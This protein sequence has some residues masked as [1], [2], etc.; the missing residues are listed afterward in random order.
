MK[1]I[2]LIDYENFARERLSPAAYGYYSD[3]ASDSITLAENRR[4]Y[5][6]IRILPHVLRDVSQRDLSATVLGQTI[7]F[8]VVIAPMAMAALAHPDKEIGIANAAKHFGIPMCLSTLATTRLETI[9]ETGVKPWFQL[10]VHRDRGLTRELVKRA[11]YAG[12]QALVVTVDVPVAG[13]RENLVRN[14]LI[15][16]EGMEPENVVDYWDREKFPSTNAYV[17][18]QFDPSLTWKDIE[19]FIAHTDIPVL[20]KGILRADDAV[21]AVES[22]VAGII[23]SNHGGRQLDTVPATIEVLPEIA[24][25]VDGRCEVL[26]DGGIRRGTDILK[27][28]ALGAKAVM[29]GRPI[30][31]GL[32]MDGQA[33]VE[34][35]LTILRREYDI[36]LALAGCVASSDI[37]R[38]IVDR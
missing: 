28:L 26:V 31:W 13:Y 15:L 35:I 10:Y 8:P 29:V 9:A 4:A 33:G 20:V 27:A 12:Y 32:A 38:D 17:A 1:P 3:G 18:A 6:R 19:D 34:D 5:D 30:L 24:E 14:P 11:E 2:N 36:A 37:P 7:E 21:Q 25:A 22:G 23:V 16:P